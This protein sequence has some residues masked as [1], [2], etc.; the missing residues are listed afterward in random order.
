MATHPLINIATNA[1][2]RAG[3]MMLTAVDR[4]ATLTI[5]EKH[6]NDY[7]TEVDIRSEQLIIESI[8]KAYPNHAILAEESGAQGENDTLWIIDPLDGTRNF[9]HGVPHFSISIAVQQ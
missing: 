5:T 6:A 8:H 3:R 7:V 2:V 1:A 4:L 9:I